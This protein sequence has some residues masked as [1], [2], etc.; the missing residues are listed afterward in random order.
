VAANKFFTA[1]TVRGYI[2]TALMMQGMN[3]PVAVPLYL[4]GDGFDAA[5][6]FSA[7]SSCVMGHLRQ[8]LLRKSD[9]SPPL[10]D[11]SYVHLFTGQGGPNVDNIANSKAGVLFNAS[12]QTAWARK[13]PDNAWADPLHARVEKEYPG[14]KHHLH[15]VF[16]CAFGDGFAAG[17]GLHV[18]FFQMR[19]K[20]CTMNPELAFMTSSYLMAGLAE[21]ASMGDRA[22]DAT[23][24]RFHDLHAETWAKLGWAN[25]FDDKFVALSHDEVAHMG[26]PS[27]PGDIH[28]FKLALIG[29]MLDNGEV[30]SLAR[31]FN[32]LL[33][34]ELNTEKVVFG[35][36]LHPPPPCVRCGAI[37]PC[38][39][40][41]Q[42][43]FDLALDH[44]E[45]INLLKPGGVMEASSPVPLT[46]IEVAS[47]ATAVKTAQAAL[48]QLGFTP[49]ASTLAFSSTWLPQKQL[50]WF[51]WG[52]GIPALCG[53]PLLTFMF[54]LLHTVEL[55]WEKFVFAYT[56][57]SVQRSR[58]VN[59][60][61]SVHEL[62]SSAQRL[63][64]SLIKKIPAFTDGYREDKSF[65]ASGISRKA[66]GFFAAKSY[67][68]IMGPLVSCLTADV[69]PDTVRRT[70]LVLTLEHVELFFCVA[71][72]P[73][74]QW[75]GVAGLSAELQRIAGVIKAGIDAAFH[76]QGFKAGGDEDMDVRLLAAPLRA[77][78]RCTLHTSLRQ[79][80]FY[81]PADVQ[82]A[83][84]APF[85][86]G[87]LFGVVWASLGASVTPFPP[88]N[89]TPF[90]FLKSPPAG[91]G[92][93]S[94]TII[95]KPFA[96][97]TTSPRRRRTKAS[98]RLK[99]VGAF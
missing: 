93:P 53:Q 86:P 25:F 94:A 38:A 34:N 12:L 19:L 16:A 54:D 98:A 60:K 88:N 10:R 57:V 42:Q 4:P 1:D 95:T 13:G 20:L 87:P 22:S 65:W 59:S 45:L 44:Y 76:R 49:L 40:P 50:Q 26:L 27:S 99:R 24:M 77:R 47:N 32:C 58:G 81:L 37:H 89:L 6:N 43:R 15:V 91:L 73:S 63:L 2:A 14:V 71:R 33:C 61:G 90:W 55:G 64:D 36:V 62:G 30:R 75:G 9:P 7:A 97:S 18:G 96:P 46:P 69:I 85:S 79:P 80:L 29:I 68:A 67:S 39:Q 8:C 83:H 23:K 41:K 21:T 56:L 84:D 31:T 28:I 35:A 5:T 11:P 72:A 3:P 82:V 92:G 78:D 48:K 52:G 66:A 74:Q 51:G 70:M 17:E